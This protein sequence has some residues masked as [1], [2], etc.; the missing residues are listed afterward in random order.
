MRIQGA[1]IR[2]QGVTFAIAVVKPHILNNNRQAEDMILSLQAVFGYMPI[3]LM[4]ESCG[5]PRYYGR[6]DIVQFLS[7]IHPAAIPWQ[8]Y[9]IKE[10][11][12]S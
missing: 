11:A 7:H 8:E 4:A 5:R 12:L 9:I 2:E 6:K 3:I 1:V 10:G